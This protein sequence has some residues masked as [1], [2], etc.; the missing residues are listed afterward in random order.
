MIKT[1]LVE[2]DWVIDKPGNLEKVWRIIHGCFIHIS[3]AIY[4]WQR[5]CAYPD[6]PRD[7]AA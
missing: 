5:T 6:Y 3:A 1:G 7:P 2:M 4:Y